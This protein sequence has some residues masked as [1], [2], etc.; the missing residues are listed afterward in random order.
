[1]IVVWK[2]GLGFELD[3]LPAATAALPP[4]GLDMRAVIDDDVGLFEGARRVAE[5][6]ARALRRAGMRA[7]GVAVVDHIDVPV[8]GTIVAVAADSDAP[9]I[10][11]GAHRRD[12]EVQL[13]TTG[14][15]VLRRAGRPVLT[16]PPRYAAAGSP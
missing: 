12:D 14:R 7:Q 15:E 5:E 16:V 11:I 3:D 2:P 6:G 13:G 4:A 1:V 9:A 10:V 8:A